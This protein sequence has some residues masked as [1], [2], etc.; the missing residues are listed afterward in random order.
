MKTPRP[1]SP[2]Q[3][4]CPHPARPRRGLSTHATLRRTLTPITFWQ[5]HV[6][7]DFWHDHSQHKHRAPMTPHHLHPSRRPLPTPRAPTCESCPSHSGGFPCFASQ[8]HPSASPTAPPWWVA[9]IIFSMHDGRLLDKDAVLI[10]PGDIRGTFRGEMI[11]CKQGGCHPRRQCWTLASVYLADPLSEIYG[12]NV[13]DR[14]NNKYCGRAISR[15][16]AV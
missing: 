7:C 1:A 11:P 13:S 9:I 6:T 8:A 14:V 4:R 10:F 16:A 5:P 15:M 2:R 12:C 3:G